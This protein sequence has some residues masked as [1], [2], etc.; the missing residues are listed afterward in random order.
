MTDLNAAMLGG[1]PGETVA[2]TVLREDRAMQL[3]VVRDPLDLTQP[4]PR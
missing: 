2:A 3:F 1:L 4:E